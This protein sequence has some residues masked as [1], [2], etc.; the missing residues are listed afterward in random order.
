ME[1]TLS[2]AA[3]D[4]HE[5]DALLV[6]TSRTFALSIPML[7]QPLRAEVGIAYLLFRIADTFE[8]AAGW[9]RERRTRALAELGELLAEPG[10]AGERA[11]GWIAGR[12]AIPH[13]GY[14]ELL[15]AAP[16]VLAAYAALRP[17]ARDTVR[18]HLERTLA[19]MTRFVAREDGPDGLALA[20]LDE[21]RDY[22]YVVA[23]IVGEML[24]ELFLLALPALAPAAGEIR[25]RAR[26]FGEGLQLVNILKDSAFDRGEG[27]RFLPAGLPREAVAAVA[28]HDLDRAG[29]YVRL[30]QGRGAPRGL[31]AFTALPVLLARQSLL[32]VE[33]RG[34][35]AKLSRAEVAA[36]VAALEAALDRG[37]PAVT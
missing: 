3:I 30:L 31:V 20:D 8:D 33:E 16:R 9:R 35:G 19:G 18:E 6:K 32:R 4:A 15:A 24:T 26:D 34:E 36:T 27:R 2:S 11:T 37:L 10:A 5:L 22:C 12:P 1:R 28:R 17:A 21:L 13:D 25:D 23:G 29:E 14:L 7:P